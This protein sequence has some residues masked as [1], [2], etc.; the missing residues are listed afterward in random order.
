MDDDYY[1]GDSLL[2]NIVDIRNATDNIC[3]FV[4]LNCGYNDGG[5]YIQ[6]YFCEMN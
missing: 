6:H 3:E 2:C 4:K 5:I 1:E